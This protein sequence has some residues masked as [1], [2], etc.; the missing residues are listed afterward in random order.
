MLLFRKLASVDPD[1]I[2]L[3]KNVIASVLLLLTM[4][5]TGVGFDWQ[6]SSH[7]WILL[8]VSGVLGLAI[9]DTLFLAGL[10]RIDASIAA[11][12]DCVYSPCVI[13]VSMVWLGE[14]LRVGIWI[15]APLVVIGLVLVSL[16][17]K[18]SKPPDG[19]GVALALAGV[20]TTAVGVVLAKPALDNSALVEATTVRLLF[21]SAGVFLFQL[22]TGR[23]KTGLVL[24]K[25]QP[26]W[27]HAIPATLLG[28][29]VSM[30]LWLGGMKYGTPSRTA[31]LNQMGA[32]F[33]LVLSRFL[34][35]EAVPRRRWLGAGVAISG[36]VLVLAL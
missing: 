33:V 35:G 29:Y 22:V 9:A 18:L 14:R 30:L 16:R 25:P 1:A 19:A 27:R 32:I 15:G 6:R 12:T 10:R 34:L 17:S 26:I 31:L 13:I 7:D 20:V 5:A 36:V 24:F 28:T 3:F 8:G 2:N 23:V 4:A 21:G 11:V